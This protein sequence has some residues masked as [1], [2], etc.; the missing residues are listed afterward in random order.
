MGAGPKDKGM[1]REGGILL[2]VSGGVSPIFFGDH[3]LPLW[4]SI[5]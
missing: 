5:P 1:S 4:A 3:H 2:A